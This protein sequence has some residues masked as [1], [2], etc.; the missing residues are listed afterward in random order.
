MPRE[1]SGDPEATPASEAPAP[2]ARPPARRTRDYSQ[3]P[4]KPIKLKP[5]ISQEPPS[6]VTRLGPPREQLGAKVPVPPAPPPAAPRPPPTPAPVTPPA[7]PPALA[8]APALA[9][10]PAL[11]PAS[12]PFVLGTDLQQTVLAAAR[13]AGVP[14]EDWVSQASRALEADRRAP[15]GAVSYDEVVVYTLRE[16]NQR[17]AHLERRGLAARWGALRAWFRDLLE[18]R[19]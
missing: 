10:P 4:Q 5:A 17:I 6:P 18:L 3:R 12:T 2:A 14:P 15:Q 19:W 9:P 16:M 13:A 8:P 7:P 1:K 11:A